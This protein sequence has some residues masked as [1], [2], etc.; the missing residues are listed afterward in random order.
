MRRRAAHLRAVHRG[1]RE[2]VAAVTFE[3]RRAAYQCPEELARALYD[4]LAVAGALL[5]LEQA[6]RAKAETKLA[7]ASAPRRTYRKDEEK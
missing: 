3:E 2:R 5:S 1:D 7:A 4:E 6:L